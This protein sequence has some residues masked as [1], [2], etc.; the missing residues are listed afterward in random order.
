[1]DVLCV[2]M[3]R[4]G[5]TWQYAV[6]SHLLESHRA[7]RRLGFVT[8]AEYAGLAPAGGWRV[9]K[10]HDGHPAFA[11][12]LAAGRALAVCSYRDLRDVAYSLLHKFGEPFEEVVE[13]KGLLRL[14][15]A[16]DEFWAA[17]PRALRQRYEAITA[18]PA[19]A[20]EALAAH[21]G[22]RLGEGEAAEMAE[23]YSLRANLWRTVELANR[24]RER[25]TDLEAD[26]R[27]QCWDE[28]TLLHW[29]HIRE[30]RVGGWR[31]QATPR[32]RAVLAGACGSWLVARGYERD[33]SWL[34]P[35]VGPLRRELAAAQGALREARAEL[36]ELR[37]LGPAALGLARRVHA[38][39]VR[40][41]GLARAARRLLR[42]VG[43]GAPATS[44]PSAARQHQ[45]S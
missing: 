32:E 23:E 28:R 42:L 21:L 12:A 39:A 35:A 16:N 2:G 19:A 41:P 36:A 45:L 33:D 43:A 8:G 15:L 44:A 11:A 25:G 26:P 40:H 9:L 4:S 14:C 38:L 7:A 6:V 5:S 31:E 18:G 1:M 3:Y 29:N 10:A 13:R 24:L 22:V 34:L 27:T 20:V 30:G 17:Q 37:R